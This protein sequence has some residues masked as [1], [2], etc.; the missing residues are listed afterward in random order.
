MFVIEEIVVEDTVA[1][2]QFHCDLARCKGA[3]CTVE[4]GRGAPL[5][6]HEVLELEAVLP[7]VRKY[8][9]ADHLNVVENKGIFEGPPGDMVTTCFN[10]QAC[11]FV[12]MDDGIAKCAIEYAFFR[13]EVRWR[14]PLS[15]HLFPIRIRHFGG[16]ILYLE[17]FSECAPAIEKGKHES[18]PL[19]DFLKEALVRAYGAEW[20]KKFRD[21]CVFI[22]RNSSSRR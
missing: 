13:G 12:M 22:D 2:T 5:L 4:G 9:S 21:A 10:H 6:D 18:R 16:S 19:Y 8:L 15:C 7:H 17:E 14:K 20:Y 3:C 1:R 11:V